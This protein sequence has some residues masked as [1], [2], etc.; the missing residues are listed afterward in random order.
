MYIYILYIDCF[1]AYPRGKRKPHRICS[2]PSRSSLES[3]SSKNSRLFP[4]GEMDPGGKRYGYYSFPPG[5]GTQKRNVTS[6]GCGAVS[7]WG[8][9]SFRKLPVSTWGRNT[10][11]LTTFGWNTSAMLRMMRLGLRNEQIKIREDRGREP[12]ISISII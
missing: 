2:C 3:P 7:L 6:D 4:C 1:V 10:Y 5:D 11:K 9:G 8:A 12:C